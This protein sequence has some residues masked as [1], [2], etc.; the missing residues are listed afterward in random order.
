M[1]NRQKSKRNSRRNRRNKGRR[2]VIRKNQNTSI[3]PSELLFIHIFIFLPYLSSIFISKSSIM[4]NF[5]YSTSS[6]IIY[7]IIRIKLRKSRLIEKWWKSQVLDSRRHRV[8]VGVILSTLSHFQI[9][10]AFMGVFFLLINTL[11]YFQPDKTWVECLYMGLSSFNIKGFDDFLKPN[12][13]ISRII[14]AI[15]SILS[16]IFAGCLTLI[17]FKPFLIVFGHK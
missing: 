14:C 17:F 1:N 6:M 10:L 13:I 3:F 4:V 16:I 7:W 8:S 15:L 2:K 9:I 12:N 5:I 11:H